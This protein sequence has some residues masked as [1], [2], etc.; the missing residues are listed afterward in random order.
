M[1][2]I[3]DMSTGTEVTNNAQ[4]VEYIYNFMKNKNYLQFDIKEPSAHSDEAPGE[5]HVICCCEF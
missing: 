1:A 3:G 4:C 2:C 5:P